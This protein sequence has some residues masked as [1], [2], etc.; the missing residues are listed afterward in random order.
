MGQPP[1]SVLNNRFVLRIC[2]RSCLVQNHNG[3]IFHHGPCDS[4]PLPFAARKMTAC[5]AH[6]GVI[7]MIQPQD[8]FMA[9]RSFRHRFNFRI[10]CLWSAHAD[11]L[12]NRQ[13]EQKVILRY[14]ADQVHHL[15]WWNIFHIN[16]ANGDMPAVCIPIRG[17]EL[18]NCR[19]SRT[20][21]PHQCR[22]SALLD[23]QIDAVQHL[24]MKVIK[25]TLSF[26]FCIEFL[27]FL[28]VSKI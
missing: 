21:W 16:T 11:I 9:A 27:P 25:F 14:I 6:D 20:G 18:R 28:E 5:A 26:C 17:N 4:N 7:S 23:F 10:C 8:K 19:F 1:D 22:C 2:V 13:I 15:F 3:G 24:C 12:P